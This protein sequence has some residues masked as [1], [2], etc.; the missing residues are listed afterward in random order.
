MKIQRFFL[1]AGKFLFYWIKFLTLILGAAQAHFF[2]QEVVDFDEVVEITT[3]TPELVTNVT[4]AENVTLSDVT[5]ALNVTVTEAATLLATEAAN[6][7]E[8]T[9]TI[10]LETTAGIIVPEFNVTFDPFENST[11]VFPNVTLPEDNTSSGKIFE[12]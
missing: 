10:K 2:A 4:E 9:A 12:W 11:F 7:T 5:E 3:G 8:E 6:V 1:L